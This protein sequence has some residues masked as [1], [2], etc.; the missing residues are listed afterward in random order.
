M[1]YHQNSCKRNHARQQNHNVKH[2]DR[3][4][5][6]NLEKYFYDPLILLT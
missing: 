1:K 6:A 4:I 5:Y 3:S 2:M